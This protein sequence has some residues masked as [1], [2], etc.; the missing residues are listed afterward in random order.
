MKYYG[1]FLLEKKFPKENLLLDL[2]FGN[3]YQN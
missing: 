2:L 1:L 3:E